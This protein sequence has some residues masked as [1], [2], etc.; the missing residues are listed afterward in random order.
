[1]TTVFPSFNVLLIGIRPKTLTMSLMPIL[2]AT[3]F[4]FQQDVL[5]HV[6]ALLAIILASISIQI[7]TNLHND[8][9]DYL[10]GTDQHSRIGPIRITQSQLASPSQTKNAAYAFFLIAIIC[11]LYLV[12]LGG[13]I[14]CLIGLACLLAG[15]GYSAGPYPISRS[16][17]GEVFVLLFFGIIA[18]CVTFYLLSGIWF[19]SSIILGV[20][21]GSPACAVLL[22]NNTRDLQNDYLAG[23]KTLSILIGEKT[24][25]G[26]YS[27]L[28]VLP[29]LII[30]FYGQG[31][32]TSWL[33]FL[34]LPLVI[35]AIVFIYSATKKEHLNKCL[36]MSAACQVIMC[37]ALSIG[38]LMDKTF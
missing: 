1:M 32:F 10:N 26:L 22:V 5:I 17:L 29:L 12:W 4:A 30:P 11:G 33:I 35:R 13:V 20:C 24:S 37:I 16:P 8:A 34:A 6:E 38:M 23:R 15:Y 28:M 27:L 18:V 21:V 9:Q 3:S 36:I 31:P 2:V 7:A 19:L 14:I 25:K